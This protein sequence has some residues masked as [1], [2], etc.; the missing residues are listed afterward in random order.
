MENQTQ[1]LLQS[2]VEN[3]RSGLDAC[4]QLLG[5]VTDGEM[6]GE[7]MTQRAQYQN[8]AQDAEKA[9][10]AAGG[11]PHRKNPLERV[12]M[13]MGVEM[14]TMTDVTPPHI[15]DMLIQ[16]ATMGIVGMTKDRND[17]PEADANAQGIASSFITAQQ[18]NIE[19]LKGYLTA[20]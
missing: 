7:L 10:Y 15:A 19:K 18:E 11:Q 1:K 5:K 12:G 3:A 14:N 6:R 13:W 16:G 20:K 9:L 2:V 17:L 4:E 8:F